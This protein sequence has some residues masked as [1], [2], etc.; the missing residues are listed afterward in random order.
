MV[1]DIFA[2]ENLLDDSAGHH[3]PGFNRCKVGAMSRV[4]M[5]KDI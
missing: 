1:V 4:R 3:E 5:V 2:G